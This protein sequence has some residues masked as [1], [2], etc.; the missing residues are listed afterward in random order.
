MLGQVAF[1]SGSLA[2][3]ESRFAAS[4]GVCRDAEDRNGEANALRWLGKVDIERSDLASARQRLSEALL[5]FEKFETR[6]ELVDCLEDHASLALA[7]GF[8]EHATMLVAAAAQ[9]RLRLALSRWPRAETRW[10]QLVDRLGASLPQEKFS[11]VWQR[12]E[13]LELGDAVRA[14]LHPPKELATA[15]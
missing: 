12:G 7:E 5:A 13:G 1:E 15:A 9:A 3:A 6:Q 14:A 8:A 11:S 4:L 2:E 10:R